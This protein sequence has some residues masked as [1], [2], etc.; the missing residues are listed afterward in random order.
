VVSQL[1]LSA[2]GRAILRRLEGL[3]G[4]MAL[5]RGTVCDLRPMPVILVALAIC[6]LLTLGCDFRARQAAVHPQ[7]NIVF[8]LTDDQRY[9][10]LEY[11]PILQRE[12]VGRGITFTNSY[13][14]TPLCC[15]SRASILTGL[16]AHN[17]GV[18][19]NGG[20]RGGWRKF[21]P[22]S[23]IGTWLQ[24]AGV[25]TMLVGKYLNLYANEGVPRGWNEWF[26]IKDTGQKYYDYEINDNGRTR[27]YGDKERWY[28][29][30]ILAQH[31]VGA[32]QRNTDQR[33]FLYLS[34]EG[35]HSPATPAKRDLNTFADLPARRLPSFNEL[36]VGDKPSWVQQLPLL[37]PQE[38]EQLDKFRRDQ[39]AT[40]Q[41]IDRAIGSVVETL[42]ADG[43]LESTWLVFMSDNG[44][45]L[46]EHRY[47]LEKSCG[48]EECV[49]VPLVIVPPPGRA[50]EFGAP[51]TDPRLVLNIDI[52]PT[53]AELA[54]AT[55]DRVLD[56]LSLVPALADPGS[57]WHAEALLELWSE[58]DS[59]SFRGLRAGSWKYLR[60]DNGE[61]ELYD[62]G[63]DPHELDN[64]AAS[65]A[66]SVPLAELSARLDALAP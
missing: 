31:A 39:I 60:Y 5:R 10:T 40:L 51:R 38:Q 17:H 56:G 59:V 30:D 6:I 62:L 52:A 2:A 14:T 42:R 53:L 61:Q 58:G 12:L 9:D 65:P 27:F 18:L 33:F 49:R 23:T 21:D 37:S 55:P 4:D 66:H 44:L 47:R 29:T 64:L 34:F 16:Y 7:P 41:A 43:R 50:A 24:A 32:L 8:F 20:S 25:R 28:S 54:G 46:G 3:G 1:A 63:S 22:R 13:V 35:P 19:T 11:M 48:Y 26:A 57:P 15:P 36:D 45:S